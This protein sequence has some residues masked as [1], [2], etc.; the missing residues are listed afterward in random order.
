MFNRGINFKLINILGDRVFNKNKA[1][2]LL[3]EL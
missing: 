2:L 1:S 3:K